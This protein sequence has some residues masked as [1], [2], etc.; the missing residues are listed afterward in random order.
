MAQNIIY[1]D[2]VNLRVLLNLDVTILE[3]FTLAP[4]KPTIPVYLWNILWFSMDQT[5]IDSP[6]T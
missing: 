2:S 3:I 4:F 6:L 5:P 1:T